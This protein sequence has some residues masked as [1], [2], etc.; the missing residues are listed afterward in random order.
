[1]HVVIFELHTPVASPAIQHSRHGIV[2]E[3]IDHWKSISLMG[4]Y[5]LSRTD[6]QR[7]KYVRVYNPQLVVQT[8]DTAISYVLPPYA[9][10]TRSFLCRQVML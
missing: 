1:M 7:R 6:A 3:K 9:Y 10:I 4:Q 2:V 8:S 5:D